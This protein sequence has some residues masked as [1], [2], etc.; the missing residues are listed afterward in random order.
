MAEKPIRVY[1]DTCVYGGVFDEEFDLVSRI[2]FQQV[3]D[4]RFLL[5]T[6][7]TVVDELADAPLRVRLLF[8]DLKVGAE[9]LEV[10]DEALRLQDAYLTAGILP[11]RR[12]T[13]ALHVALATVAACHVL[14]SWNFKHLVHV[15]LVSQY[16]VASTALGYR[17]VPICS[18]PEVIDYAKN[19]R[20]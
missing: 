12:A 18:P 5:V 3:R 4:G 13:D 10:G 7:A 6:S 16:N 14:V 8:D 15:D 20:L 1:V 9:M 11:S 2:F 19:E 17:A